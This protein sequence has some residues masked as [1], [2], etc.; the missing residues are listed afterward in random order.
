MEAQVGSGGARGRAIC[1]AQSDEVA[2]SLL[3]Q[4]QARQVD[5]HLEAVA[6][7]RL[8]RDGCGVN[9]YHD[10]P[11]VGVSSRTVRAG[12][13]ATTWSGSTSWETTLLAPT[14]APLP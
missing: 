13:P 14:I 4:Q 10:H 8:E 2:L 3:H 5:Q 1:H 6:L 9:P 7:G 11:G 12:C